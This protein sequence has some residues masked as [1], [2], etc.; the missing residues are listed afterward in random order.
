MNI[1]YI[2]SIAISS[3]LIIDSLG[4]ILSRKLNFKYTWLSVLSILTFSFAAIYIAKLEGWF[5]GVFLT[6]LLGVFDSTIG[7]LIAKKLKA[8]LGENSNYSW[9]ISPKLIVNVFLFASIIA[10]IA[11]LIA[12]VFKN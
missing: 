3:I 9:E 10:F 5:I 6:G 7:L 4:S 8:N 1:I 11:I 12:G 2:L